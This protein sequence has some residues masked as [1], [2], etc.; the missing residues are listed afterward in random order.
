M[1][2]ATDLGALKLRLETVN[3]YIDR[4]N[5][6]LFEGQFYGSVDIEHVSS[7]A[8]ALETEKAEIINAISAI[9]AE[10]KMCS[11]IESL[12]DC[13]REVSLC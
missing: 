6:V 9:E 13:R 5:T 8:D 3:D 7:I 10:D 4:A 12:L 2:N 1:L 11:D